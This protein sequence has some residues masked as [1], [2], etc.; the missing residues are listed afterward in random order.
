MDASTTT[1]FNHCVF[2]IFHSNLNDIFN[3]IDA[4]NTVTKTLAL[5]EC[6]NGL[7]I[8]E[9]HY[10]E[11][12][13]GMVQVPA[14]HSTYSAKVSKLKLLTSFGGFLLFTHNLVTDLF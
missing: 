13:R 3:F 6:D 8:L 14:G 11:V 9:T 4:N 12:I 1:E 7:K 2:R 5:D 10:N